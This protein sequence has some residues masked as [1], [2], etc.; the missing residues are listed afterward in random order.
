MIGLDC[1]C[2]LDL[3]IGLC[4]LLQLLDL[5]CDWLGMPLVVVLVA[6]RL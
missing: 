4:A 1:C 3:L 6:L 2:G 5:I